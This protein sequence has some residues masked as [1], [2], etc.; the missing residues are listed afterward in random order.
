MLASFFKNKFLS[1]KEDFIRTKKLCF[2]CLASS[3]HRS[4]ECTNRLVCRKC[5]RPHPTS[6][7]KGEH[8]THSGN[9]T[10]FTSGDGKGATTS[11]TNHTGKNSESCNASEFSRA[12]NVSTKKVTRIMCPAVP[13]SIRNRIT[14]EIFIPLW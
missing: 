6:L 1:D 11:N 5:S 2:G 7:H 4:R 12:M 14:D 10:R 13:I 8:S 9:G 3:S